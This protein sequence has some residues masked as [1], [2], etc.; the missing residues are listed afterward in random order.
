MEPLRR[1]FR[2]YDTAQVDRLVSGLYSQLEARLHEIEELRLRCEALSDESAEL[3]GREERLKRDELAVQNALIGAHRQAEEVL[4]QARAEAETLLQVAREAAARHQ[5]DLRG[6]IA[7]LNW[8]LERLS[9][10]KQQ[11]VKDFRLL[12]ET[13]LAQL[14]ETDESY[15]PKAIRADVPLTEPETASSDAAPLDVT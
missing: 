4:S 5:E 14:S 7:D 6:R 12:L 9:L 13:H 15:E 2:G 1:V 3:R 8:Q 10:Q 11:F